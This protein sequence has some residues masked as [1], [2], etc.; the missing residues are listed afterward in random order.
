MER[1]IYGNTWLIDIIF[2]GILKILLLS[3]KENSYCVS[4]FNLKGE[5]MVDTLSYARYVPFV[6]ALLL[7][8]QLLKINLA[9]DTKL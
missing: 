3:V 7:I 5:K 8:I 9:I 1:R 6:T 2:K 4:R